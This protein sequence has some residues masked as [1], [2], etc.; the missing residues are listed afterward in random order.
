MKFFNLKNE[1][2]LNMVSL[3][4]S[5][6]IWY[7]IA[8]FQNTLSRD[9]SKV[10]AL[11][12]NCKKYLMLAILQHDSR[13]AVTIIR[14]GNF[15]ISPK[16][17]LRND[18]IYDGKENDISITRTYN[19]DFDCDFN[20]GYYPFDIQQCNMNFILGVLDLNI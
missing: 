2:Y 18:H 3:N 13:S 5:H 11:S 14:N 15:S 16:E 7:P 6:A 4:E 10:Q 12:I 9:E 19:T 1:S 17:E 20:M 8:I